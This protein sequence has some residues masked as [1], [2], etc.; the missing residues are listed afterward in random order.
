VSGGAEGALLVRL[1]SLSRVEVNR[2]IVFVDVG[3]E[4]VVL[5]LSA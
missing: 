3:G 4:D 5:A 2:A 1:G